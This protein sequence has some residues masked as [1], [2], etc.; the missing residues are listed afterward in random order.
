MFYAFIVLTHLD[1]LFKVIN[2]ICLNCTEVLDIG[3]DA[4]TMVKFS[5]ISF[6]RVPAVAIVIV[7]SFCVLF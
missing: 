2:K 7:L 5:I 4:I 6:P 3:H 1:K